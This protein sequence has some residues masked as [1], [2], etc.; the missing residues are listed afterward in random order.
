[1]IQLWQ[2][3]LQHKTVIQVTKINLRYVFEF[4]LCIIYNFSLW[5]VNM[6][7]PVC[8]IAK[9]KSTR[10]TLILWPGLAVI[11]QGH[12]RVPNPCCCATTLAIVPSDFVSFSCLFPLHSLLLPSKTEME[13]I[14]MLLELKLQTSSACMP[15]NL[16]ALWRK[17]LPNIKYCNCFWKE[18]WLWANF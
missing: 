6:W 7:I 18:K 14:T 4:T 11:T 16:C 10:V 15:G 9:P 17:Q 8:L 12:L 1:M 3:W 2:N 13:N 5:S